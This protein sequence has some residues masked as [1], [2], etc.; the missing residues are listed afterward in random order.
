MLLSAIHTIH[1]IKYWS[2]AFVPLAFLLFVRPCRL[3]VRAQAIWLMVLLACGMKGFVYE[4]FGGNAMAPDLPELLVWVWNWADSGLF[5]LVALSLV[6]WVRKGRAFILPV[7]AW[8]IAAWGQYNGTVP[9]S[10]NE[11]ELSF[12]GLPASLEGYRIAQVS[13]LHCSSAARG[14]RTR[15]VVGLVNGL[16]PDLVCLTGDYADGRVACLGDDLA[17]LKDLRAADG[18]YGVRGNHEYYV[19][20]MAWRSWYHENGFVLLVNECVFPRAGLALGGVNDD[21][22]AFRFGDVRA[23]VGRAFAAATNGE[24][25]VLMEH[26]P[27]RAVTNAAKHAVDLQLS[28]HTHGGVAPGI[29]R[30]VKSFNEGFVRGV[31]D[32]G[33]MKLCVSPG[34]GQWVGFPMRFFNPAEI[35]V[36]TLRKGERR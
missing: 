19:D 26:R 7:L 10:V 6:W 29:S 1:I 13:D 3:R 16:K 14:W 20:R 24:F 34:C 18:V 8:G 21:S 36:I 11:I 27:I 22:S 9:P 4:S 28:G 2:I 15:A 31:Y 12:P 25:R 17:P 33:R 23:D 30:I 32:I 35:T 5:L